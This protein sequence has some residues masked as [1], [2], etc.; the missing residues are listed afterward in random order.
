MKIN[1]R[2]LPI[3]GVLALAAVGAGSCTDKIAFGNAFLEKAPGG[4][5]TADTVFSLTRY[6]RSSITTCR[7]V[8]R[9]ENLSGITTG[10]VRQISLPIPTTQLRP[11]QP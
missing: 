1:I 11:R 8:R 10:K 7:R 9:M 6:M 3:L 4:T 5:T 2:H